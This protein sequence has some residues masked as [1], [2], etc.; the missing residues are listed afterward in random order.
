MR[1]AP[2]DCDIHPSVAHANALRP[3]LSQAQRERLEY[4]G[5][6]GKPPELNYF[7]PGRARHFTNPIRED[8]RPPGGGPPASDLDFMREQYLDPQNIAAAILIPLQAAVVDS[9]T[10]ADEAAWYVSAFND[11]YCEEWLSRDPRFNLDMV[12][13]P[14]DPA[15][16]VKEIERVGPRPGVCAVWLPMIDR[17]F[18]DRSFHPIY[19]AAQEQGLPIMVHTMSSD[20]IVG[21]PTRAGGLPVHYAERYATI[22][23]FA[24]SNLT[25]LIFEGTFERFP[26]LKFVF[27]EFGWTWVPFLLWRMDAVW[28]AARRH[29][30]WM[31]KSP[32][33]YVLEHVRFTSEPML[34]CPPQHLQQQMQMAHAAELLLYASDYPHWDSEEPWVAFKGIDDDTRRRIYRDNALSFFGDRLRVT[35]PA[36]V[37]A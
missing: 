36:E 25:S 34:E 14:Q 2:I 11:L 12:V 20:D 30:P 33:D 8:C 15:L 23:Q 7:P 16:A 28:K 5:I 19:A 1:L 9:W 24:M 13:A 27:V 37:A 10:Y 35:E 29:H 17:L 22:N 31:T 26:R 18:G 4:L 6:T 32:T 21:T 3:Y